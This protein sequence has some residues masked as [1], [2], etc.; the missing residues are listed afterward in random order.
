M[1]REWDHIWEGRVKGKHPASHERRELSGR[2]NGS[3]L[4]H[5]NSLMLHLATAIEAFL[6]HQR[7]CSPAGLSPDVLS[8][9]IPVDPSGVTRDKVLAA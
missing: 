3:V 7:P 9:F 5:K 2:E 1:E 6:T 4:G 8:S